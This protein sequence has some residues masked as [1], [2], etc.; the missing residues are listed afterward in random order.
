VQV[1]HKFVDDPLGAYLAALGEV[2]PL[3]RD[4]EIRCVKHMRA[5]DSQAESSGQRLVEANL[6]LVVSIVEGYRNNSA[7][8][9]DLIQHGNDGLLEALRTFA[10]SS[11]DSFAAHAPPYIERAITDA[12]ASPGGPGGVKYYPG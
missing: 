6:P 12:I 7:Y 1:D 5:R 3:G 10:D 9:L 4:E 2:P 11:E 8:I